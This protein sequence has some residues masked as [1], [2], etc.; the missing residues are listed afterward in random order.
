MSR[1]PLIWKLLLVPVFAM[2]SFATY[3]IYSSLVLSS[4][5]THLKE[6]RDIQFPTLDVAEENID[7][8]E[9]IIDVL[10]T[11]AASGETDALN[12]AK[13]TANVV[14]DR[15]LK[16]QGIDTAHR[17]EI[18]R[19]ASEFDVYFSLAFDIAQKMAT[20]FGIPD[21]QTILKMRA[22][23]DNYITHL[24]E[25]RNTA[26]QRFDGT[27]K[28]A[29]DNAERARIL[30]PVIGIIMLIV[31]MGLTLIITRGILTLEKQ[32]VSISEETQQRIG[33]ELHDDL[34]QHL[35]GI[36]FKS[37]SLSQ[38]LKSQDIPG[39]MEASKI[40]TLVN[41]AIIKTR[42]LAH[43][44]YPAGMEA[45]GLPG[46]L[47]HLA[48]SIES[49]YPV[50]C[51][52]ICDCEEKRWTDDPIAIINLFRIA[53]EA[54][55]NAVKHSGATKITL[56]IV[57][58]PTATTLEIDDNGCGINNPAESVTK[59]GLG[60]RIMQYRASLLGAAL[61]VVALPGGGTRVS[62]TITVL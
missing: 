2:L 49:I 20:K 37:E 26:E 9:K 4:S 51:S 59:G 18:K 47:R 19:L 29:T 8:I 3:L 50:E 48:D 23:R 38:S 12:I 11:A 25:F 30:G 60:M 28:E 15:Y 40:T 10:N 14:R 35:T 36:A 58:A 39:F 54:V 22:A 13:D 27:V 45:S 62:T 5:N 55:N 42:N 21:T 7:S 32:I 33:Q 31:L 41:E 53:Q 57:S 34:G 61:R 43:S 46:M 56:K 6:I 17:E 16:L 1:L 44:L 52:L 24:T